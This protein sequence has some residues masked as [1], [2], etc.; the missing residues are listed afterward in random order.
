MGC[1]VLIHVSDCSWLG[2]WL[3]LPG[4][5]KETSI[6]YLK[7]VS[8]STYGCCFAWKSLSLMELVKFSSD[9][10]A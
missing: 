7:S 2:V 6:W 9:T 3:A 4:E 8:V 1:L 10:R 5:A